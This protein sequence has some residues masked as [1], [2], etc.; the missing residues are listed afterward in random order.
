MLKR[1]ENQLGILKMYAFCWKIQQKASSVGENA[2]GVMY[3]SM[4]I[5]QKS[6]HIVPLK[7]S[8]FTSW[9]KEGYSWSIGAVSRLHANTSSPDIYLTT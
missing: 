3:L 9:F 8:D 2:A 7:V 4:R 6:C 5:Y 1:K